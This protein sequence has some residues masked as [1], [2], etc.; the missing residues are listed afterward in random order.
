M[1]T[2]PPAKV[3]ITGG[4]GF[5]G[6]NVASYFL[7][8]NHSVV[9]FDNLS[10]GFRQNIPSS[11]NLRFIEGD[12]R[13]KELL[14]QSMQGCEAVLHL[15]AAV[16][17]VR[18]IE[19][20]W[21]DSEINVLGTLNVLDAARQ[22]GIR[23]IVYSSSAAIFGEPK[24]LPI[25]EE[26]PTTPD[27]PYGVSKLS[28]E[29]HCLCYA[30]LYEMDIVCLRYFNVYGPNQRYDAYG[31]VI[32]IFST[33][34]LQ[35]KPLIIY[36]NGEQTRDFI[37]V[38]DVAQANYLG[39]TFPNVGGTY[40]IGTGETITINRLTELF[41]QLDGHQPVEVLYHAPRKGEVKHSRAN[42]QKAKTI[43]GFEATQTI[44]KGLKGYWEWIQ[45]VS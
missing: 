25:D 40:N 4:A 27:S 34:K 20:T 38:F 26:H 5:I 42:I 13:N 14:T 21:E 29:L 41:N 9:I 33:R 18:S 17:N 43:L 32:P 1:R 12:I 39:A 3:L 16:G 8:R 35:R 45:S 31:N 44:E 6:S 36:G 37:Y 15:A 19:N 28:G 22:L 7:E 10:T 30:K 2:R 24:K 23:K 11:P